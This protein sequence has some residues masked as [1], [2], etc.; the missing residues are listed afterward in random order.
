MFLALN[1]MVDQNLKGFSISS[2]SIHPRG[3]VSSK[4]LTLQ[5]WTTGF[6]KNCDEGELCHHCL[7]TTALEVTFETSGCQQLP[8]CPTH[9]Y[10]HDLPQPLPFS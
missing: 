4:Y 1:E 5:E 10:G 9:T 6:G 8:E 7:P 2:P 3:P